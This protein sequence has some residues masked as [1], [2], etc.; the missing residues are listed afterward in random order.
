M[1]TITA[2]G[3]RTGPGVAPYGQP[4]Y[5]GPLVS[6]GPAGPALVF[7]VFGAHGGCGASTVAALL[8]PDRIGQAVE[9]GPDECVS[10]QWI[11][12][13]VTR[14]SAYGT[15]SACDLVSQ[16]PDEVTR[17]WLV[18]VPDAP[19]RPPQTARFY[20]RAMRSRT[21]GI[22]CLPYLSQLRD[23]VSVTEILGDRAVQRAGQT[24]L[25]RLSRPSSR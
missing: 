14:S 4:D 3:G 25:S 12:V 13:V 21:A 22:T 2:S 9:I 6:P 16:W 19:V 17:P 18:V 5:V 20:L 15:A 23:V 7:A 8:D 24:L 11:P 1:A 10:S